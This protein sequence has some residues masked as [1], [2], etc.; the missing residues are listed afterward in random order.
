MSSHICGGFRN[1]N[2]HKTRKKL[3]NSSQNLNILWSNICFELRI[4]RKVLFAQGVHRGTFWDPGG[5]TTLNPPLIPVN[6]IILYCF[7]TYFF[8]GSDI[9]TH[10]NH[11]LTLIMTEGGG[12]YWLIY[13]HY[14]K[15]I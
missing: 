6:Q 4:K 7:I 9:Q 15:N 11:Y 10:W 12:S 14:E 8:T 13:I 5:Y 2:F 3:L 1:K